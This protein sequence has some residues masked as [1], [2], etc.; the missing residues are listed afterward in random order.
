M[1]TDRPGLRL[2]IASLATWRVTNLLV[3]EDGPGEVVVRL[4]Q[5]A[6]DGVVG[7]AMDCFYCLSVW[8][9]AAHTPFVT[10]SRRDVLP[11]LFAISGTACLL[12]RMTKGDEGEL[13]W[14]E[15]QAGGD[16]APHHPGEP[17]RRPRRSVQRQAGDEAEA[18]DAT[19]D[20]AVTPTR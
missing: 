1:S 11:V 12:Q 15:A 10:R 2:A 17:D 6:G 16:V 8:V 3:A 4:R 13:L 14:E 7:S 20:A 9:A 5:R 18:G 19:G